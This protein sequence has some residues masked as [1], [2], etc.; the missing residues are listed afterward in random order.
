MGCFTIVWCVACR[1]WIQAVWMKC[2]GLG[3]CHCRPWPVVHSS[4]SRHRQWLPTLFPICRLLYK[5][6]WRC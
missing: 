5:E 1:F 3:C 4:S 6:C 2:G